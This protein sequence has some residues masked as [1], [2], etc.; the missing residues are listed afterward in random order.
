[1]TSPP[2]P[3]RHWGL[4]DQTG[5]FALWAP[6]AR[7]VTFRSRHR[8]DIALEPEGDGW[9]AGTPGPLPPGTRYALAIDGRTLPDPASRSQPDGP[10]GWS[11][12]TDPGAFTW[13]DAA[14]QGRPWHE[15]VLY[16]LH[17]GTFTPAGTASAAIAHLDH[18]ARLGVTVIELMPVNAFPGARNW[19]YDGVLPF[20]PHAGYGRPDDLKRFVDRAHAL[21]LA[22]ILDVVY[23]HFGPAE[24]A[25]PDYAPAFFTARHETPWGGAID[26]A[27][28]AVRAFFLENALYWIEE[29]HLDGLRLD[30]VQAI[31]DDARPHIL[32]AIAA[33]IRAAAPDRHIHLTLENDGN[34]AHWLAPARYDAQWNDDYHHVMRV[35]LAGRVDGYYRDYATD[36]VARLGRAL[37]E[38]FSYQGDAVS[39]HR[40]G[41]RRG[42]PSAHLPP[43]SFVNFLQNHDQVGNTPFGRRLAQLA[44]PDA[45]RLGLAITLLGPAIPMLFMGEEWAAA[46]PFD[47]FCDYPDDL[48]DKVRTGRRAEF[49]HLPEFADPASLAD[50]ADPN[51]AA[52]SRACVLHW[53]ALARP[54]HAETLAYVTNLLA[55]RRRAI[56]PL[57]PLIAAGAG[58]YEPIGPAALLVTWT[59]TDARTLVLAANFADEPSPAP[60]PSGET[61][62]TLGDASTGL[63]PWGAYLAL[64]ARL[65]AR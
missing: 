47:F 4:S 16:E 39:I 57:L 7:T 34:E 49:S 2:D 26:F 3:T 37:A 11:E 5:R 14:W 38:G 28:P 12:V 21:G 32:D 35:L 9:F 48:A 53:A 27:Q 8:P 44:T 42:T 52:T 33:R 20:A 18:L 41:L 1:M 25:I 17:L 51:A 10:A 45:L 36:P 15:T 60:A 61:L 29:F 40:P 24:N 30:A 55:I 13:S 46:Q 23:N 64:T 19:G 54:P 6:A 59:L 31:F 56:V 50:L 63:A 43:T 22:V 62:F 65:T 58:R